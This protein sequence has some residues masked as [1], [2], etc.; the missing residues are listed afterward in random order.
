MD[1][2]T[3]PTHTSID[4]SQLRPVAIK[5]CKEPGEKIH[6]EGHAIASIISLAGRREKGEKHIVS[7]EKC[8]NCAPTSHRRCL[9]TL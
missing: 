8:D 6:I 4:I 2:L 5:Q 3:W 7:I 9:Q 1:P